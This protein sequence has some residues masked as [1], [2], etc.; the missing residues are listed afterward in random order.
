MTIKATM[1]DNKSGN[2][3]VLHFVLPTTCCLCK[4]HFTLFYL[5]GSSQITKPKKRREGFA[6]VLH[7]GRGGRVLRYYGGIVHGWCKFFFLNGRICGW[8]L[9][10]VNAI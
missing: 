5:G 3:F 9:G 10:K 6:L 1:V 2:D 7:Q 8:P 4:Q